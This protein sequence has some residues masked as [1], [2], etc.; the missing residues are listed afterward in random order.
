MREKKLDTC[1]IVPNR[2]RTQ[3]LKFYFEILHLTWR[4][5]SES[6]WTVTQKSPHKNVIKHLLSLRHEGMS[7]Y[8]FLKAKNKEKLKKYK[9]SLSKSKNILPN[10]GPNT[11]CF[12][13][14]I[15]S[16]LHLAS[17]LWSK[18]KE[19]QIFYINF[20]NLKALPRV[21]PNLTFLGNELFKRCLIGSNVSNFENRKI[22]PP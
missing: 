1:H 4:R 19:L 10:L 18:R 7:S 2:F 13:E 17:V 16:N 8:I 15:I 21:R 11:K 14:K 6:V 22:T 3:I 5:V 9:F 12:I 20:L